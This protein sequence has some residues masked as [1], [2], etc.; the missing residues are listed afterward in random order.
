MIGYSRQGSLEILSMLCSR[1]IKGISYSEI[2]S[3]YGHDAFL[4]EPEG[5]GA[6]GFRI[7]CRCLWETG[8]GDDGGVHQPYRKKPAVDT[9]WTKLR[10]DYDRIE[11]I[12]EPHSTVLDLGC[13]RGELLSRLMSRGKRE[14]SGCGGKPGGDL[15]GA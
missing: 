7:H 4:L 10:V 9:P 14:R 2:T 13:G 5:G 12:I 6:A 1:R 15:R 3:P 11:E 8:I